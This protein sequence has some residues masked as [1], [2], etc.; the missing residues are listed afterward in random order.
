MLWLERLNQLLAVDKRDVFPTHQLLDHIPELL[1]EIAS[2]LRAP[3]DQEIAAN[4]PSVMAKAAELGLMR[5]DQRASVHQLLREYQM[6]GE[7]VEVFFAREAAILGGRGDAT[8]AV[9]VLSPRAA[10]RPGP[11]AED[12]R[13]LH[14]PLHGND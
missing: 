1:R 12:G 2:Y 3:A 8:A 6:L 13:R 10:G 5:F 11:A 14:H 4:T 9:L 7:I